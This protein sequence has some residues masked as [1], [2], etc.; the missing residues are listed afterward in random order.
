MLRIFAEEVAEYVL[1]VNFRCTSAHFVPY[2]LVNHKGWVKN[3]LS[4]FVC[5][6]FYY[7]AAAHLSAGKAVKAVDS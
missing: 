7:V 3:K 4:L 1:A 2:F 5:E 6:V